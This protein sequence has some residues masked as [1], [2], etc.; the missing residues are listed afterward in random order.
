MTGPKRKRRSKVRLGRMRKSVS[1]LNR[2]YGYIV[3]GQDGLRAMLVE[4]DGR[5]MELER[6]LGW[7][8]SHKE[9][10]YV[11]QTGVS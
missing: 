3:Q 7:K 6:F 1:I 11:Q 2:M 5:V 9:G 8:W 4:L 10:R